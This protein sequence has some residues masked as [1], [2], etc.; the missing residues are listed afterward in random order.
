LAQAPTGIG[1]TVG[2]LFPALKAMP[3][4]S[5]DKIFILVAKTS[6]R[7]VVLEALA[8]VQAAALPGT[9]RFLEVVARDKACEH[10]DA[11]CH[12]A[13]CPLARGFYDRLA[14]AREAA[15]GVAQMDRAAVRT[16][17]L[18]HGI[19]PYYLG[20][21]LA[22]WADVLVADY[23]YYFDQRALLYALT[24]ANQWKVALLVDEAHN[25]VDRA[26]AMYTVE[27][28]R[29]D[30]EAARLLAPHTVRRSI[31]K[32]LRQWDEL[33]TANEA[34]YRIHESI[35]MPLIHALEG[36][37]AGIA[38]LSAEQPGAL[39]APLLEFYF[40][41]ARFCRLANDF[42]RDAICD[43]TLESRRAGEPVDSTLCV[44]N[45]IPTRHLAPRWAAAHSSVLFS[46][47]LAP[48]AFYRDVLGLDSQCDC[49]DIGTP[50]S[51]D[52]LSVRI[53][54]SISTRFRHR[55]RSIQPIVEL[56]A[57]H[58]RSQPGNYLAFF[59][60]FQYLRDV[61]GGL[62]RLAR[63]IP[64]WCQESGMSE[65]RRDEFLARFEP[66]GR[67]IGF[68]VLGGAFGEGI[69]LPGDRLIGA[70]VATLGL[71]QLNA[72]NDEMR[73]RLHER[74]GA[75]YE[76]A[77][78]YPGLRKVVQ[79]AGRVIRGPSDRGVV[80][81]I[82]DRFARPEVRRLLPDWWLPEELA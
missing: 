52:Q 2:T 12:G 7:R 59:S 79:A 58:Y 49:V 19:C 53:V 72:M 66:G 81:L 11:E 29:S 42:D 5:L 44:R 82:D 31:G 30:I 35:P 24:V 8:R 48:F 17:A 10:P 64:S 55:E 77:Y 69:D 43:A 68:A 50:F 47:T 74:F 18:R 38:D 71:P 4:E 37:V 20:Q 80:Y 76:Y 56:I 45:V 39:V 40:R 23:N 34:A 57:A 13:S 25:L 78:L 15:V 26:R 60:S 33:L 70:F 22:R 73:R 1:K 14:A 54:R 16:I 32:V 27:L 65:S 51:S 61:A 9:L 62:G 67:G 3:G 63:E 28:Q 41:A 36:C 21:E 46:A 75:G 6:G